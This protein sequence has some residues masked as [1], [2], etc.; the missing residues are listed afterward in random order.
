[1]ESMNG[2]VIVATGATSGIGQVASHTLAGMG[3]RIVLIARDKTRA[4]ATL[5]TLR[6]NNPGADHF[7]YYA[8]LSRLDEMKR[9][10]AEIAAAES[11]VDVLINNAGAM[12]DQRRITSD[13]L[14]RT[15]A[16]NHMAYF[17][18]T[19][20]LR[21]RLIATPGARI[22]NTSSEAHRKAQVDYNDLQMESGFGMFKAYCRSKLYNLL[23]THELSRRLRG[24]GV[25]VNAFHPGFVGTRLGNN[26]GGAGGTIFRFLKWFALTPEEGAKTLIYLSSSDQVGAING[27][28]FQ[29]CAQATPTSHARDDAAA[30]W[31]WAESERLAGIND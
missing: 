23:F 3:S 1:M 18:V 31:L 8:D 14:E 17:V 29:K 28:Y 4:E 20:I 11:R 30:A 24:T 19:H 27:E 5:A 22:I 7:V 15:F 12:F 16:L 21:E 9:V 25:T 2:K 26:A 10:A 13:G 6:R